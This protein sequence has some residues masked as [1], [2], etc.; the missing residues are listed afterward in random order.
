MLLQ[1]HMS[2][3]CSKYYKE[4]KGTYVFYMHKPTFN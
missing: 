2:L 4:E 3:I 1:I